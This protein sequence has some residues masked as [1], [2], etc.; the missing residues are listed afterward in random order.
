MIHLRRWIFATCVLIVAYGGYAWGIAPMLE[1]PPVARGVNQV[2]TQDPRPTPPPDDILTL[3]PEDAWERQ[4]AK[5]IETEQFTL[6][7]KDYQT[8][9]DG[10]LEIKPA[11]LIFFATPEKDANGKPK[12]KGR[13]IVLRAP[14]GAVL[15]F[16]KPLDF[17]RAEFGRLEG[18]RLPGELTIFSPPSKP[19]ANDALQ[20]NTRNLQLDQQRAYTPHDVDFQYGESYGRGRDLTIFLKPSEKGGADTA[21]G[22]VSTLQLSRIERIHLDLPGDSLVPNMSA[23]PAAGPTKKKAPIEITC[24]GMFVFDFDQHLAA[25]DDQV[26]ITRILAGG[27]PDKLTCNRLRIYMGDDATK[28]AMNDKLS[29]AAA[30]GVEVPNDPLRGVAVSKIVATGNPVILEGP[31]TGLYVKAARMELM[32][33]LRRIA[34]ESGQGLKQVTLKQGPHVFDAVELQYEMSPTGGLGRLWAAGPGHLQTIQLLSGQP[35][36]LDAKWNKELRIQPQDGAQVVSLVSQAAVSLQA[37]GT[38]VADELHFWLQEVPADKNTMVPAQNDMLGS[39]A[40]GAQPGATAGQPKVQIVP[41]RLLALRGVEVESPKLH[42]KTERLEAWFFKPDPAAVA[43]AATKPQPLPLK[44]GTSMGPKNEPQGPPQ[45]FDVTGQ[46]VQMRVANGEG[47]N[48]VEDL[49]IQGN[50]SIDEIQT[51]M[52]GVAPLKLRGEAVELRGGTTPDAIVHV[53]GQPAKISARGL[54]LQ[55]DAIHLH[56]GENRVWI[57]GPGD[58]TFP[59]PQKIPPPG[60]PVEPPEYMRVTWQRRMNFDGQTVHLEEDVQARTATQLVLCGMLDASITE[61][62]DF[63]QPQIG[64]KVG[65]AEMK[66]DGGVY[67]ENK[68]LDLA[69]QQTSFDTLETPN[70]YINQLTGAIRAIGKGKLLTLRKGAIAVPGAPM[71]AAPAAGGGAELPLTHLL[72]SFQR[73]MAGDMNKRTVQFEQNVETV[74]TRVADWRDRLTIEMIDQRGLP[75]LGEQGIL[76]T[77]DTMQVAQVVP[78]AGGEPTYELISEGNTRVDGKE[79]TARAHRITYASLKDMLV[80]KG[81]GRAD[82]E[83]WYAQKGST[84]HAYQAAREFRYWPKTGALEIQDGG[85]GVIELQQLGN[86][87]RPNRQR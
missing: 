69:G 47:V 18:G 16:D 38:F 34:L 4:G 75:A 39:T 84:T 64:S 25:F 82:A 68:T 20:I 74:Y 29:A 66:L 37:L 59:L 73:G 85:R 40:Y 21:F 42:A 11:T 65:L 32:P 46:L 41:D 52:P 77:S 87:P 19:G 7:L 27:L 51:T 70:L 56:R 44:P 61:R 57:D 58:A 83:L 78:P 86:K 80:V 36:T 15:K 72:V 53:V 49:T 24:R 48:G 2:V 8:N 17:A 6:L 79:F 26:E 50:A 67:L 12:S 81:D 9:T 76:M 1:P 71:P 60:R 14:Q 63:S 5:K 10:Q 54:S 23:Q 3:F 30:A 22:G 55:G 35:R 45:K 33:P 31:S 43:A 13:P 28:K 62:I